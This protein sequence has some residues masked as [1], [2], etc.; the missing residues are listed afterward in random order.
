M[1]GERF[2]Q[3]YPPL[4]WIKSEMVN[5]PASPLRSAPRSHCRCRRA[6]PSCECPSRPPARPVQPPRALGR[7][8]ALP[9]SWCPSPVPWRC[10]RR[11]ALGWTQRDRA[12]YRVTL[13]AADRDAVDRA[14]TEFGH[15][16]ADGKAEVVAITHRF[17]QWL[18]G[19]KM[20]VLTFSSKQQMV[21]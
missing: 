4:Q 15:L 13:N 17:L 21:T 14:A 18:D 5:L 1:R 7:P 2:P 19:P 9:L 3:L 8:N 16:R 10:P 6:A 20:H 11:F 12:G